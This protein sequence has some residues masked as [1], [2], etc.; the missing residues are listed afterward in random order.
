MRLSGSIINRD[1]TGA[2]KAV[3]PAGDINGE[4]E[5]HPGGND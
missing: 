5:N 2:D 4:G 3:V 1:V